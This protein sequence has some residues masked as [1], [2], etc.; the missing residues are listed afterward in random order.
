MD[1][2]VTINAAPFR[3]LHIG[4]GDTTLSSVILVDSKHWDVVHQLWSA[5]KDLTPTLE[6]RPMQHPSLD[7]FVKFFNPCTIH[8]N[9]RLVGYWDIPLVWWEKRELIMSEIVQ[10]DEFLKSL[11]DMPH[12]T[13]DKMTPT[14][15]LDEESDALPPELEEEAPELMKSQEPEK[16]GRGRPRKTEPEAAQTKPKGKRGRPRK[17]PKNVQ[18]ELQLGLPPSK[19]ARGR[20]KRVRV[21]A[22]KKRGRPPKAGKQAQKSKPLARGKSDK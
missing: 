21:H 3:P 17:H 5:G 15:T 12:D 18:D 2:V 11:T 16:R 7:E 14:K 19:R 22:P 9:D 10:S 20:P 6:F 13:F 8:L 4:N 1:T